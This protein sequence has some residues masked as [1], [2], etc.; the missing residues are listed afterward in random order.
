MKKMLIEAALLLGVIIT[1]LNAHDPYYDAVSH[2]KSDILKHYP[3]DVDDFNPKYQGMVAKIYKRYG[4]A[5][6]IDVV[7]TNEFH[8]H[9]GIY[10][11]IGAKMGARAREICGCGYDEFIVVSYVGNDP[12][13]SCLNDGLQVSTGASLGR[14]T[15]SV[16]KE[17]CEPRVYFYN[18]KDST[19]IYLVIKTE[20]IER[21]NK[22]VDSLTE[23]YGF[24]SHEY[25]DGIEDL[26][27]KYWYELDR[28]NI[29]YEET[30]P[31]IDF[32][33]DE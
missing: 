27:L 26:S 24:Q 28:K 3:T 15:I 9:L 22:D 20:I 18:R 14:G 12:P 31:I 23:K 21:I 1:V 7:L 5:E 6:F 30:T 13:M 17:R 29:F 16:V 25:F 32:L 33:E 8:R 10:S 11:I 4:E 19:S 2:R